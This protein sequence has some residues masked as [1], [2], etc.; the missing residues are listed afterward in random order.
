MY[1]KHALFFPLLFS[2]IFT[3]SCTTSSIKENINK[4][5]DAAGQAIGEFASGVSTGVK[6]AIE[7]KIEIADALK[8]KGLSFGKMT[9]SADTAGTENVLVA[10]VIFAQYFKGSMTAKA[11]DEK[12]LEMGR[13][14][15]D[16][17]GKKD[18]AKYF[19]F[20][21][22]KRTNIKNDSRLVLE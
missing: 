2:M 19:E 3:I 5:G 4:T 21:F 9:I 22:D 16:V 8:T 20:H 7:P 11:F 10:Y 1:M 17:I 15:I 14:K 18:E 12:N 13:V 6:K